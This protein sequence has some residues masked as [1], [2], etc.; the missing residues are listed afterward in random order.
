LEAVLGTPPP[1]PPPDVPKIPED[2]R[3]PDGLTLR[4]RLERHRAD[5]VCAGCHARMD[6]IGFGLENFDPVGRWRTTQADKPIDSAGTLVTGEAFNG[7]A[8]LKK[9]LLGKK[10]AFAKNVTEKLLSYAL[11]R[12]LEYYDQPTVLKIA[13]ELANKDY[14]SD[15]LVAEIVKSYPFRYRRNAP[16]VKAG[17]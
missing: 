12:G 3:A 15:T 17:D 6:P 8:E 13:A 2:D 4:Q 1:P 10:D 11:G 7:P 9:V 5:P 14:R 16:V